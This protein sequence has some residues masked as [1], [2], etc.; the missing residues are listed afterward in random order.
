MSIYEFDEEAYERAIRTE[1]YERGMEDGMEKGMEKGIM[2]E[3]IE[4]GLDYGLP[5]GDIL[6]RLQVKL[7]VSLQKAQEYFAAFGS[8]TV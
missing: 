6:E 8:Q 5:E 7:N 1:E 2:Q 4:M 3:I